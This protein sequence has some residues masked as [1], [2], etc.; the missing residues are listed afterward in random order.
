MFV[1]NLRDTTQDAMLAI[2][3]ALIDSNTLPNFTTVY[4]K[5]KD[6]E[7]SVKEIHADIFVTDLS[8]S[9]AGD[10]DCDEFLLNLVEARI[11]P[12]IKFPT[13][14]ELLDELL[15]LMDIYGIAYLDYEKMTLSNDFLNK[16]VK[17]ESLLEYAI[18][19]EIFTSTV[20]KN[21]MYIPM[22]YATRFEV[23]QD[24]IVFPI[25]GTVDAENFNPIECFRYIDTDNLLKLTSEECFLSEYCVS[26]IPL[27][28]TSPDEVNQRLSIYKQKVFYK[29]MNL[30]AREVAALPEEVISMYLENDY[31]PL[32]DIKELLNVN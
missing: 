12:V 7:D 25:G 18:I 13:D 9:K 22:H 16:E 28:L 32:D 4:F 30:T 31:V 21:Y 8:Q 1:L 3:T 2:N 29:A 17:L 19:D 5:T 23:V 14:K 6:F 15:E 20:R 24:K 10:F 26:P 27:A 11:T